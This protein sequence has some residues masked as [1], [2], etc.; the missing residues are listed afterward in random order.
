MVLVVQMLL[1][2]RSFSCRSR[3]L[4]GSVTSELSTR[5]SHDTLT[6]ARKLLERSFSGLAAPGQHNDIYLNRGRSNEGRQEGV[7]TQPS[8]PQSP[9][10]S[11]GSQSHMTIE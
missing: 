8:V 3:K 10:V 9:P 2:R 5:G 4:Y 11:R 6:S 1:P 7:L